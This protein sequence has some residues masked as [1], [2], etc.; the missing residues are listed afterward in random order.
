MRSSRSRLFDALTCFAAIEELTNRVA[1]LADAVVV[2]TGEVPRRAAGFLDAAGRFFAA[3][4]GDLVHALGVALG[5]THQALVFEELERRVDR[6]RARAPRAGG[7]LLEPLDHV[8]SVAGLLGEDGEHRGADVA[9]AHAPAAPPALPRPH[10]G[11]GLDGAGPSR[12]PHVHGSFFLSVSVDMCRSL[13]I[14]QVPRTGQRRGAGR[15]DD[16]AQAEQPPPRVHAP[17]PAAVERPPAER[18]RDPT[19]STTVR[20]R[21]APVATSRRSPTVAEDPQRDVRELRRS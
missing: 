5:R 6:A 14:C 1:Q 11:G 9:P 8:V 20:A 17:G 16:P 19:P 7:L 12:A 13:P 4:R 18:S 21:R 10:G 2:A 3:G 15:H